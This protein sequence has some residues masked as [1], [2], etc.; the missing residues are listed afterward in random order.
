MSLGFRASEGELQDQIFQLTQEKRELENYADRVTR[1]LRRYQQTRSPPEAQAGDDLPL[2]P[3]ATNMQMM[4][5]L[6]YAYEERI[7]ELEAVIERSVSLAEQA[8]A[9]AKQNDSLRAELQEKT[10]QLRSAHLAIPVK[11]QFQSEEQDELRELYRICM[12]QNEALAQQNQLLKLQLERMQQ[13]LAIGQQQSQELQTRV[14]E[15]SLAINAESERVMLLCQER[16][17]AERRLGEVTGELVE[18]VRCKEDL[19]AQLE[20]TRR[21]LQLKCQNFEQQ[22][23]RFTERYALTEDEEA[24]LKGDLSHA[25]QLEKEL[26]QKVVIM[27]RD[28]S[29]TR[30]ALYASQQDGEATRHDAERMLQVIDALERKLTDA[31]DRNSLLQSKFQEQEGQAEQLRLEKERWLTLEQSMRRQAERLESKVHSESEMYRQHMHVD[32]ETF[33]SSQRRQVSEL[34]EQLRRTEQSAAESRTKLELTERQRAWEVSSAER[35]KATHASERERLQSDLDEMHQARLRAE[36]R[37]DMARQE[38]S[39]A[40]A[41]LA[42]T[43]SR[44]T[45]P[46][47]L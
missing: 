45:A 28:L 4:S 6:L 15:G 40:Q 3:W 13:S 46:R 11:E 37:A 16:E 26:R 43:A 33:E 35:Q 32:M 39:R 18:Q 41:E 9:L 1:E 21:E 25:L 23:K 20:R 19:Q 29:E 24:R 14:A 17:A 38:L 5:P 27:D 22:K 36:R 2:P 7:A 31:S 44:V 30:N 47:D 8:Q 42:T 10:E 34:L 12:E